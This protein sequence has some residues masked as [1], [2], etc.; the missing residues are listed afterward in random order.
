MYL[1][2]EPVIPVLQLVGVDMSD[3]NPG[4]GSNPVDEVRVVV[5]ER[6]LGRV[7]H[8]RL[9]C[10]ARFTQVGQPVSTPTPAKK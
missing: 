8:R 5:D 10:R 1:C 7:L 2:Q 9:V 4:L 3:G 6:V